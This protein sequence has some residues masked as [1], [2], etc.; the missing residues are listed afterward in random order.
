MGCPISA[1]GHSS[2]WGGG[3]SVQYLLCFFFEAGVSD[4][5]GLKLFKDFGKYFLEIYQHFSQRNRVEVSDEIPLAGNQSWGKEDRS[6]Y[7]TLSSCKVLFYDS[8]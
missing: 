2:L 3:S 5:T 7:V 1:V 8:I 4:H 6:D